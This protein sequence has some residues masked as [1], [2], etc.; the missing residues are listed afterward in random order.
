[1]T[2]QVTKAIKVI[3]NGSNCDVT[4]SISTAKMMWTEI[5]NICRLKTVRMQ[6]FERLCWHKTGL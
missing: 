2:T 4:D 5:T 1:M 6:K 3:I